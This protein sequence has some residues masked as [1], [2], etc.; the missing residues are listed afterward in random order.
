ML[1]T[2]DVLFK[3]VKGV[4]GN[5]GVITLNRPAALNALTH[6]MCININEMLARW[7]YAPHIKAVLINGAG[8]KAFSAGGD[9]VELYHKGKN[10]QLEAV[11]SFFRDEYN[12][13]YRIRY[14]PKP[15]ISLLDGITM[16]GGVGVSIHG[17]HCVVTERFVFAMPETAIGFFPDIGGSYFLSRCP[18]EIGV[19]LGLTGMRLNAAEAIYVELAEHFICSNH[20]DEVIDALAQAKFDED[21]YQCVS[22]VLQQYSVIPET[23]QIAMERHAIDRC[24]SKD[25][26]EEI[27]QMLAET[28]RA[29]HQSILGILKQ[30]SPLSLK[31]TLEE[32]RQGVALDFES[33][34]QMEFRLCVRFMQDHDFYEGVRAVLIDKDKKPHWNP[35]TIEKVTQDKVQHY[36]AKLPEQEELTFDEI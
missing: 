2:K 12:L 7:S 1:D 20:L 13:N 16:G 34:M 14:F 19:Y 4:Q 11:R 26:V 15:F 31:I 32:I 8:D 24:F 3:E 33:C 29:W 35:N 25:S 28:D 22:E 36:F 10:N 5:L 27:M 30:K 23:P 18:G 21:P 6:E 9:I 17:S